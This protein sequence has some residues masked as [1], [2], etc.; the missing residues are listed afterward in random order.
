MFRGRTSLG[1]MRALAAGAIAAATC[2]AFAATASAAKTNTF[3]G[4]CDNVPVHAV[5]AHPLTFTPEQ[6]SFDAI[7]SGGTCSGTLNGRQIDGVPLW[8]E[9]TPSGIQSCGGANVQGPLRAEIAGETFY[10]SNTSERRIGGN[11]LMTAPADGSGEM[12]ATLHGDPATAAAF[13]AE[14]ASTGATEADL[15]ADH[16]SFVNV[17]SPTHASRKTK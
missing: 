15:I 3:N 7:G 11:S 9:F 2:A 6:N 17:V 5:W 13:A 8:A 4:S 14:C 16:M 10:F 12:V 1:A